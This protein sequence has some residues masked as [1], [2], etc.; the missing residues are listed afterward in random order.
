MDSTSPTLTADELAEREATVR[1]TLTQCRI[2]GIKART[3]L[4]D[5]ANRR[6]ICHRKTGGFVVNTRIDYIPGRDTYDVTVF[7]NDFRSRIAGEPNPDYLETVVE[8]FYPNVYTEQLPAVV[9]A[10]R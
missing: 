9:G 6:L 8:K 7:R 5:P 4:T 3:W 2:L 1:E 10:W